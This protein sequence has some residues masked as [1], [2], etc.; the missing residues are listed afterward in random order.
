LFPPERHGDRFEK[1]EKLSNVYSEARSV[2]SV[3]KDAFNEFHVPHYRRTCSLPLL[4]KWLT[5]TE[6]F[7][8]ELRAWV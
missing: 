8:E 5:K 6:S 1:L 3:Y 7:I 4:K 2:L